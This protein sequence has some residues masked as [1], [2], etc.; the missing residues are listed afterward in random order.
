MRL[1]RNRPAQGAGRSGRGLARRSPQDVR[2]VRRAFDKGDIGANLGM[3]R[4]RGRPKIRDM[5]ARPVRRILPSSST[6]QPLGR[7]S[8]QGPS[9]PENPSGIRPT[10]FAKMR[11]RQCGSRRG[12]GSDIRITSAPPK[13]RVQGVSMMCRHPSPLAM[14]ALSRSSR[15]AA[16]ARCPVVDLT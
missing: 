16:R 12:E 10:T 13:A 11:P 7:S 2:A 15:R 14:A 1:I 8:R 9:A 4:W 6:L 3:A 5:D